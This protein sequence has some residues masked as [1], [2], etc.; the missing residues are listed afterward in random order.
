M[1]MKFTVSKRPEAAPMPA[2][3]RLGLD[4]DDRIQDARPQPI[5]PDEREPIG[6]AKP[7]PPQGRTA[8][9]FDLVLQRQVF[10]LELFTRLEQRGNDPPP[11]FYDPDHPSRSCHS[12]PSRAESF[13]DGVFGMD[14]GCYR[15]LHPKS[16]TAT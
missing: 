7:Q 12:G 16:L 15:R 8:Q 2:N 1:G 4:N 14:S 6:V 13:A 3:H 5:E 10:G 11:R 9:Q